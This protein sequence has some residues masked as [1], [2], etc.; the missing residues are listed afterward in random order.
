MLLYEILN[1]KNCTIN[2]IDTSQDEMKEMHSNINQIKV[3]QSR[4]SL[5]HKYNNNESFSYN[6]LSLKNKILQRE[7]KISKEKEAVC[8]HFMFS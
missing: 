7:L 3:S 8:Y 5:Y 4:V 6:Y 1:Q 2:I